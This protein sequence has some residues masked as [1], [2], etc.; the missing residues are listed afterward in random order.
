MFPLQDLPRAVDLAPLAPLISGSK[1]P[2]AVP[3]FSIANL[4]SSAETS[5]WGS[6]AGE[7]FI[8]GRNVFVL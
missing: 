6:N 2:T 4:A 1:G 5:P 8:G 3:V 7:M